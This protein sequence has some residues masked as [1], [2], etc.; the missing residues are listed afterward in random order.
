VTTTATYNTNGLGGVSLAFSGFSTNA[1]YARV[2]V[3]TDGITWSTVR[4]G[5]SVSLTAGAGKLD[6]YDG[7]TAGVLNTYRVTAVDNALISQVGVSTAA[8]G[9]NASLTAAL[10]AGVITGDLLLLY[11][12]IRNGGA[13]VLPSG[14]TL[15]SNQ[16]NAALFGRYMA[17]GVTAPTVTFTGGVAGADTITMMTAWRNAS[18]PPVS[19]SPVTNTTQQ[20]IPTPVFTVSG[21]ALALAFVWKQSTWTTIAA[22]SGMV[23][24]GSAVSTAGSGAGIAV[25]GSG[26]GFGGTFLASSF[27]ITGGTAAVSLTLMTQFSKRAFTDQDTVTITPVLSGPWLKNPSRPAANIQIE[28]TSVSEITRTARTG[29]FPVLNRTMPIAITDLQS[30]RALTIEIDCLGFAARADMDNRLASGETLFLQMPSPDYF[31]PTLYAVAGDVVC[32]Q[33]AKGST[34][35]TFQ[36]PL[37][38]VAKPDSSVFGQTYS[39]A[40]VQA[41]YATWADVIAGVSTWQNL[42][43]KVSNST[44]IVP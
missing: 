35:L 29:L 17:T 42:M 32:L 19:M 5:D 10:P 12:T 25:S 23:G 18:M 41:N 7:F 27:P 34:S 22:Q 4:G 24:I 30:S 14:W 1:D 15:I 36:V 39:W 43:D 11:A 13:P 26:T 28:I 8:S 2:E 33:D 9:N 37:T 20:N 44:I 21:S 38:E 3:S 16:G 6:D 40:D 31:C